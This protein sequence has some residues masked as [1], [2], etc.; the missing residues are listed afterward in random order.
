[1]KKMPV[2]FSGHGIPMIALAHNDL[3]AAFNH[4]GQEVIPRFGKPKAILSICAH[5]YAD[6][7]YIQ[8]AEKPRQIYDMYGFPNGLYEV[9]YPVSGNVTLPWTC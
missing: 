7:T 6:G 5:G 8:S 2:T 4:I 3:T 9:Q 1:M